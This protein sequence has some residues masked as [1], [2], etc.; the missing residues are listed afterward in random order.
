M[1]IRTDCLYF[2]TNRYYNV[3]IYSCNL[4]ALLCTLILCFFRPLLFKWRV[5][6]PVANEV[7]SLCK[8]FCHKKLIRLNGVKSWN[9]V[10]MTTCPL[11]FLFI[12]HLK[13]EGR[14]FETF[15]IRFDRIELL[16][17]RPAVEILNIK[18]QQKYQ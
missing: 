12:S 14:I 13:T 11:N 3:H 16:Y 2:K 15:R 8:E 10:S 18:I 17:V 1:T 4:A 7:T 6:F 5:S 9:I